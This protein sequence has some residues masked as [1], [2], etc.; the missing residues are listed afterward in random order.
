M[1]QAPF[2][3]SPSLALLP[4]IRHG[5]FTR[6]GG[7]SEGVYSSLN[8]GLGSTDDPA[9]VAENR[10]RVAQAMGVAAGQLVT[11]YQVHGT[12]TIV[13]D[14]PWA[15][16]A[17]PHGDA[18]VTRTLGIAIAIGTA[19]CGPV[20][21]A[22]PDARVV[23]AAHA[24]WKGAIG[25]VLE[26]AV[27]AMEGLGARRDRIVAALGPTISQPN[28]EVG[29]EVVAQFVAH[30]PANGSFFVPSLRP[31]RSLF[32]LPGYIV[33]RLRRAGIAADD[34]GL[35]T[36]A[37]ADRFFSFRRTTHR[38]EKDYGRELSAIVLA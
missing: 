11:P 29:P 30:D 8:C 10:G 16:D 32:D 12:A 3:T 34:W 2:L 15:G 33:G 36:Y 35:C 19:D 26:S 25:G 4:G 38:G 9:R 22:D 24:G 21:F 28:Y 7:V 20:L 1:M 31:G 18:L 14:A 6:E 17:R 37:D 27:A 5:F 23:G 13:V